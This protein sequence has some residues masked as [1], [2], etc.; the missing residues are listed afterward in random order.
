MNSRYLFFVVALSL[1]TACCGLSRS[2]RPSER[3]Q[4][5]ENCRRV[6]KQAVAKFSSTDGPQVAL[7]AAAG[8]NLRVSES[9][10]YQAAAFRLRETPEDTQQILRAVFNHGRQTE[11]ILNASWENT[12]S[13]ERVA[14]YSRIAALNM[15]QVEIFLAPPERQALW[16]RIEG[17]SGE[18]MGGKIPIAGKKSAQGIK[19]DDAKLSRLLVVLLSRLSPAEG[20]ELLSAVRNNEST[21]LGT[22]PKSRADAGLAKLTE[23]AANLAPHLQIRPYQKTSDFFPQTVLEEAIYHE[24]NPGIEML[25]LNG[26]RLMRPDA[27]ASPEA[28]ALNIRTAMLLVENGIPDERRQEFVEQ[29]GERGNCHPEMLQIVEESLEPLPGLADLNNK[30]K[31]LLQILAREDSE[32]ISAFFRDNDNV[33]LAWL[34]HEYYAHLGALSY[35]AVTLFFQHLGLDCNP[36]C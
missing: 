23:Q 27:L 12:G 31:E 16:Q 15:R 2:A 30:E 18:V 9:L 19:K 14:R 7:T 22:M 35:Q 24:I 21:A 32:A 36:A 3:A 28:F 26:A 17:A 1:C 4:L 11:A 34:P 33:F 5:L 10:L 20:S 13:I 6:S 29:L 25:I 8:G